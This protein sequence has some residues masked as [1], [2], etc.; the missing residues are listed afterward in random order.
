MSVVAS[1]AAV[2]VSQ[3]SVKQEPPPPRTPLTR[4]HGQD[5]GVDGLLAKLQ[6]AD[7]VEALVEVGLHRLG[8]ARLQ[9][10]GRQGGHVGHMPGHIAA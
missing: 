6:A 7:A 10:A 1:C 2:I 5:V 4:H 3:Q 9:V 8:A